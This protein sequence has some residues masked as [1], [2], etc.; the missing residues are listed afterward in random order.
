MSII[1]LPSSVFPCSAATA[2]ALVCGKA[3]YGGQH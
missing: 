2:A 3:K 1:A